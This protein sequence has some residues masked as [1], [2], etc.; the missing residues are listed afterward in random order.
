LLYGSERCNC[1]NNVLVRS[2]VSDGKGT[3]II[4]ESKKAYACVEDLRIDLVEE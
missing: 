4:A 3:V 2:D 1:K